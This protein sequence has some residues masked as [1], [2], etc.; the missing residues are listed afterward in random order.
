MATH[1]DA[2]FDSLKHL[3]DIAHDINTYARAFETIGNESMARDLSQMAR[4]IFLHADAIRDSHVAESTERLS[5][6]Q[7]GVGRTLTA[8]LAKGA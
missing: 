6:A 5:M 1:T 4:A 8:L 7:E 2:F 3:R